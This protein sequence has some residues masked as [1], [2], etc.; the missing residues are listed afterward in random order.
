MSRPL[1]FSYDPGPANGNRKWTKQAKCRTVSLR[2]GPRAS[3]RS[4][5][6]RCMRTPHTTTTDSRPCTLVEWF[7]SSGCT[8]QTDWAGSPR[9]SAN[10]GTDVR[11]ARKL[12]RFGPFSLLHVSN[13]IQA[14]A[15]L[16]GSKSFQ[17]HA[18]LGK[19]W[20]NR[21]LSPPWRIGAPTSGKSWIRHCQGTDYICNLWDVYNIIGP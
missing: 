14:V 18:V 19:I 6:T 2:S 8:T 20:Q 15:D 13:S 3:T 9:C 21:M 11:T 1:F 5:R 10:S 12:H 17:F 16:R 7:E 4:L